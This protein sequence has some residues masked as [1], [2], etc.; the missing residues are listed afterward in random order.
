MSAPAPTSPARSAPGAPL[1]I[2]AGGGRIPLVVAERALGAGRRPTIFGIVGEAEPG[3]ERFAHHWLKWGEIGR[4]FRTL[5]AEGIVDLVIVGSVT[6][7]DLSVIRF[8][9]GG[10]ASLPRIAAIALGGDDTVL[11]GVVRFF[12]EKGF[13]VF[14]AHE[15]APELVVEAGPQGRHRPDRRSDADMAAG[16]DAAAL[17]GR[18]DI[19]QAVIAVGGRVVAVEG[20]EGTDGL[21]ARTAEMREAGRLRWTGRSGVLVKA[22]KPSQDLR[23]DLPTI[24]PRTVAGV[25]AAGLAGIALEAGRVMIADRPVTLAAADAAG[26][27]LVGV[28]PGPRA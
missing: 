9:L 4:L 7:P 13:R 6:R 1:G 20:A 10:L 19:G 27:F 11:S 26:L 23:V 2:I 28:Q 17:L 16:F 8:D 25:A 22:A 12:E 3:I 24:G 14:G 18:L 15:I 5:A 21:L